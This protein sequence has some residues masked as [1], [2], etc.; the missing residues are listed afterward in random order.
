[1]KKIRSTRASL[2]FNG[3]VVAYFDGGPADTEAVA[4]LAANQLPD[5]AKGVALLT[6]F[7]IDEDGKSFDTSVQLDLAK[8]KAYPFMLRSWHE[9]PARFATEAATAFLV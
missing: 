4:R 2:T 8:V 3:K 6:S 5:A 9:T 1:M 7:I